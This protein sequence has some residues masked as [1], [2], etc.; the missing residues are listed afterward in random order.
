M[1]N[2][3]K[4]K[5]EE[6]DTV[7]GNQNW[8]YFAL[9]LPLLVYEWFFSWYVSRVRYYFTRV[10]T[11]SISSKITSLSGHTVPRHTTS[12]ARGGITS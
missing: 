4:R 2:F 10:W 11:P 12:A 9:P 6:R 7:K 5:H 1:Y 3:G 8:L